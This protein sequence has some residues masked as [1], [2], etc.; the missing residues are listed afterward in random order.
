MQ[1]YHTPNYSQCGLRIITIKNPLV[2][3]W[4]AFGF[5]TCFPGIFSVFVKSTLPEV[6]ACR[7]YIHIANN[8]LS[9]KFRQIFFAITISVVCDIAG[10]R[11]VSYSYSGRWRGSWRRRSWRRRYNHKRLLC[12]SKSLSR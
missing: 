6:F 5:T 2:Y 3:L 12:Y 11:T 8:S 9:T 4:N 10:T 1:E 7:W